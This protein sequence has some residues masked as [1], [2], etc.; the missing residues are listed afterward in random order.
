MPGVNPAQQRNGRNMKSVSHRMKKKEGRIRGNLNAK[1]VDQSARSVITPDPNISID[2][3]GIPIKIAMNLT[4]PEVVNQYNIVKMKET[5]LIGPESWPGA[6]YIRKKRTGLTI[7]IKYGMK[8]RF[9]E[10]L[11]IGDIVYRHMINDDYV[12]FNRQPSLHKMSMMCHKAKIMPYQT[13]R[14]NVLDTPPYNADFDGDE[15]NLHMPQNDISEIE[16]DFDSM[17]KGEISKS[18]TPIIEL[19]QDTLVGVFRLTK[20]HVRID[21]KTM[22]NLQMVNSY[23]KG[24][25]D[26]KKTYDGQEAFSEILPNGLYINR[27]NKKDERVVINNSELEKGNLDKNVFH[28][29][30]TGLI[31]V[32]YHD[33]G[34]FETQKFLDN[35]QRL[36]CRWLLTAGF[37]KHL[38]F[39][40]FSKKNYCTSK[41]YP[42]D[43]EDLVNEISDNVLT[44]GA[45]S[46]HYDE[47]LPANFS[48]F[49][50]TNVDVFA[51][52]VDIYATMPKDKYTPNSGTSMAAPSTAGIAALVRSYYPKL[53]AS[54]ETL[55]HYCK[56]DDG[57]EARTC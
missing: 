14:L 37:S 39:I 28:G 26:Y 48:N 44:I 47:K 6:K 3:L 31:P 34:P 1:R 55:P 42:N 10:E 21:D 5:V 46:L 23:F 49:G 35:T 54:Q 19:V 18:G 43:S 52:G 9:S 57:P 20:Q 15:M 22:A 4:F 30:T 33:Y 13:F 16:D 24:H 12:L 8:D 2:E 27:K 56:Y 7:N 36:I 29:I 50:K 41:T 38:D 45:M 51:P 40:Y 11:E 17:Y 25:L 32:I 53:S